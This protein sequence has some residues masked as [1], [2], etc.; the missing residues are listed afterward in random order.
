MI[1]RVLGVRRGERQRQRQRGDRDTEIWQHPKD[2]QPDCRHMRRKN[3][4]MA[5]QFQLLSEGNLGAI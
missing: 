4:Q 3:V 1:P 2:M 5:P